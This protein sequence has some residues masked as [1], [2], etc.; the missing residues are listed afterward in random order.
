M[1]KEG[2]KAFRFGKSQFYFKSE[3]IKMFYEGLGLL[4]FFVEF[5]FISLVFYAIVKA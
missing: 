2:L 1:K 3:K 4:L 5:Y